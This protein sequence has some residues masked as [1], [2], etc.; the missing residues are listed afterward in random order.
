MKA[1][2]MLSIYKA[3]DYS[4]FISPLPIVKLKLHK[5]YIIKNIRLVSQKDYKENIIKLSKYFYLIKSLDNKWVEI[6]IK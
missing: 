5:K 4:P 1:G 6:E 2:E 3:F